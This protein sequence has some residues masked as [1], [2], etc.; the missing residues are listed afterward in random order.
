MREHDIN[1][2]DNFVAGWYMDDLSV[3]DHIIEYHS[4]AATYPGYI[5][6]GVVNE[7]VKKSVDTT[8]DPRSEAF[9]AY[10]PTLLQCFELYKQKYPYCAK[11]STWGIVE[12]MKVSKYR[13]TDGYYAWHTERTSVRS[14]NIGRLLV[15]MTYLND[16]TDGGQTEFFHQNLKIQPEK[17]LTLIWGADWMFTHRG[18]PSSTQEKYIISGWATIVR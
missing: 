6:N 10:T 17:G 8:L 1:Q 14:G 2:L 16:V 4:K 11:F 5:A 9:M 7:Q 13:P 15:F 18:V 12:P 3:C